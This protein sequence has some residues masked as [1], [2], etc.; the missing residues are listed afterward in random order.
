MRKRNRTKQPTSLN[1]RLNDEASRLREQAK[2]TDH[3]VEREL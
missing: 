2:S 3:G 1:Q